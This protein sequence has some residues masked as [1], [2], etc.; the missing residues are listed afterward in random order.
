MFSPPSSNPSRTAPL[1][2]TIGILNLRFAGS[3][4]GKVT[5]KYILQQNGVFFHDVHL[6]GSESL[7][8]S[9]KQIPRLP[10]TESEEVLGPPKT[11]PK[12]ILSRFFWKTSKVD[13]G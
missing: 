7:K 6:M 8:R 1:G 9:L 10:N 13:G 11:Y 4:L 5:H 2:F 3:M 12:D